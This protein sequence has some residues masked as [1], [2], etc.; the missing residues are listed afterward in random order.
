MTMLASVWW[1]VVVPAAW[2]ILLLSAAG[3][4]GRMLRRRRLMHPPVWR[5]P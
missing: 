1:F 3:W 5:E 2:G 4:I